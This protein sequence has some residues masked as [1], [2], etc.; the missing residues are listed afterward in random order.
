MFT[1]SDPVSPV[2]QKMN[3]VYELK[4]QCKTVLH[5]CVEILSRLQQRIQHD[6]FYDQ[7]SSGLQSE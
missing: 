6:N 1:I 5:K 2:G 7:L 4:S 3:S